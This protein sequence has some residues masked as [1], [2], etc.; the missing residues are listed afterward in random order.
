MDISTESFLLVGSVIIFTSIFVSKAGS[1]FGVPALLLFL[2]VGMFFGS[3]GL[4]IQFYSMES[5]QAIGIVALSIILFS[6]GM[7]TSIAEIRPI[8][9]PGILLATLGVILT[10]LITGAFIYL[11]S[12]SAIFSVALSF[13]LSILLAS[14]MSSTDSASVFSLLRSQKMGLKN[15]LRPMLELESGSNDPVAYMLT[16]AMI[17]AVNS[18]QGISVWDIIIKFIIQLCVGALAGFAFGKLVVWVVNK[19]KLQNTS[20]YPILVLCFIFFIYSMTDLLRGNG[21]LAV[22]IAGIIV[23]NHRLVKK[24]ETNTFL[25]GMTWLFQIIM[26]LLLGLLV[27]PHEMI[28]I[29]PFALLIAIFMI[30]VARPVSVFL[31]LIPFRKISVRSKCFI[32]WVGLRGAVPILFATYPVIAKVENSN[33][34]FNIVFFITILSLIIQ[35]TTIP[36]MAKALKLTE[37]LKKNGNDFGI[38][39]PEEIGSK[40]WDM[41]VTEEMLSHGNTL[42]DMK[43]PKGILVIMIKRGDDYIIP[44]GKTE[45]KENDKFLLATQQEKVQ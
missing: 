21:Y 1:K 41:D 16:I 39:F 4:G 34:F 43:M 33:L 14:T 19:I 3:D 6:G 44:D 32:S 10:A 35:G 26:F 15:N 38:T 13:P 22:Y 20:L 31:T 45:I 29:A 2:I 30:L 42:S 11:I 12:G 27:N 28:E 17:G 24:S 25:D 23:G 37:K 8:I 40:L 7:D 5:A 36:K 18:G 9:V